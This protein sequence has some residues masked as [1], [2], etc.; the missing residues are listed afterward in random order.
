MKYSEK[1]GKSETGRD[2]MHHWLR[3]VERLCQ[4]VT[5]FWDSNEYSETTL[6]QKAEN[7][8]SLN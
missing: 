5:A 6:S 1:R 3:G 4:M 7:D 2:E 8:F